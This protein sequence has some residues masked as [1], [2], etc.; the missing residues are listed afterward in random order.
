MLIANVPEPMNLVL[1]FKKSQ[2]NSVHRRVA[3]PLVEEPSCSVQ[4]VEVCC[5]SFAAPE[6]E[7]GDLEVGPKVAGGV[8]VCFLL[9]AGPVLAIREPFHGVVGV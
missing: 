9:I 5:V 6:V 1:V 3:P 2:R 7:G 8:A 4:V